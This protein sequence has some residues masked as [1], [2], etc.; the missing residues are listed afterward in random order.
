M[1]VALGFV[2]VIVGLIMVIAGFLAWLGIIK[3]HELI[4]TGFWDFLT[5][6]LDKA[7]WVVVV[8]LALIYFGLKMIGVSL[9]F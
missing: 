1:L 9:P 3:A 5:K 6:L 7:P 8:G 4:P 2:F